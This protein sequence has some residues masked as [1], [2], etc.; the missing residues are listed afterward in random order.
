MLRFGGIGITGKLA[1]GP[2][3]GVMIQLLIC[4]PI[5]F[6]IGSG[7]SRPVYFMTWARAPNRRA[8]EAGVEIKSASTDVSRIGDRI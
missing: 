3:I 2:P 8:R 6:R 7:S 4:F 5:H 1:A